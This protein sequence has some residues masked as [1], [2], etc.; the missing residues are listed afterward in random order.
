MKKYFF[1]AI[2]FFAKL[3]IA[4]ETVADY[5]I[6][7]PQIINV[8]DGTILL[9]HD[10]LVKENIITGIIPH[11]HSY[12]GKIKIIS[13]ANQ[14]AIPALWDM[15]VHA[16]Y[17]HYFSFSNYLMVANGIAGFRDTWGRLDFADK[18]RKDMQNGDIPFQRF[19]LSGNIIDGA[20]KIWP[21]SQEAAT[22]QRGI[23]LVD[24]LHKAGAGFI[25]VYS[26]LTPETFTA[27]AKRCNELSL[28]FAGHVP[29]K[30]K[31]T[32]ASNAG[33]YSMEHLYGFA[34]AFSDREDSINRVMD[35]IDY[36]SGG[37]NTRTALVNERNRLLLNSNFVPG[38][39][40]AVTD[41]LKNNNTWIV[42]TLVVLKGLSFMDELEK[43]KDKR[44]AYLP[45][46]ITKNWK[47]K[48]D[49]R[50]RNRTAEQWDVN[51]NL[52]RKIFPVP[53]LL[54]KNKVA[55]LS[56]TDFPNPYCIPGFG[57]HDEF[58]LMQQAG[59]SELEVLQSSTIN[60]ARYLN[61]TDSLGTIAVNKYADILLLADNPL[62]TISNTKKIEGLFINGKYYSK[63]D[64]AQLKEK[65]KAIAEEMDRQKKD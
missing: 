21:G 2:S 5:V 8:E 59:L 19:I 18:V 39:I 24:S 3:C 48:N 1:I 37:I 46:S 36:S 29:N 30:V 51:K 31:L 65:A 34:E 38:K 50:V 6:S 7:N 9:N 13:A 27:I 23:E 20:D 4:Q 40:K 32:D 16:L 56:G 28:K 57:L 12:P 10:I 11:R 49:F 25:K 58:E 47:I 22:P 61:K 14:Y 45:H 63:K 33:M 53:G 42:P 55:I 43:V 35:K 15:H 41:V 26:R 54:S 17:P 60:A 52:Y 62:Q 44:L 64:L